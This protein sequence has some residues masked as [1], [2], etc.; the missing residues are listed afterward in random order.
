VELDVVKTSSIIK[1]PQ[2]D[3][4]FLWIPDDILQ[5]HVLPPTPVSPN[6]KAFMTKNSGFNNPVAL[7]HNLYRFVQKADVSILGARVEKGSLSH[8]QRIF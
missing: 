2:H 8:G 7:E 6:M 5:S 1:I 3:K 4:P